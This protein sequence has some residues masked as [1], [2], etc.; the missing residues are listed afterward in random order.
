MSIPSVTIVIPCFNHGRF[1]GEAVA[2]CVRQENADVRVVVVDDGSTDG[3]TPGAC[4]ALIAP[5]VRVIHQENLGLPA[6]RNRGA[7][8]A[9]TEYLVFLDA[10]DW[11]NFRFVTKLHEAIRKQRDAGTDADVAYA[12]CYERL[13]GQYDGYWRVPDFDP[14]LMMFS[15]LHPVTTLIR[16]ERFE[17]VGGFDESMREGYEDWDLWLRFLDRGWRGVRVPEALFVWRRHSSATM[18]SS[19]VPRHEALYERLMRQHAALYERHW[20]ELL[21]ES[22]TLL[23]RCDMTWLDESGEPINLRALKTQREM[24]ES[25]LVVRAHHTMHR[26]IDRLP[27]PF[28]RAARGALAFMHKLAPRARASIRPSASVAAPGA[29]R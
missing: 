27:A 26:A 3:S 1:V 28:A 8:E 5:R 25:M 19:A 6:A 10:D 2:S 21:L 13:V 16:R 4:D 9:D 17:A 11:I 7:K 22:N 18:I 15:N 12:Y 29:S 23:R 20:R 14:I 24:Y